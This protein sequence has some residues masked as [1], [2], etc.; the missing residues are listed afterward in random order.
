MGETF[1]PENEDQLRDAIAWAVSETAPLELAGTGTKSAI[2]RAMQTRA[3]LDLSA[4]TGISLYEPEELVLSAGAGTLRSEVEAELTSAGQEFAFEPPDFSILLGSAHAGTVGGMAAGNLA[5]PRRIKAGAARDHFLG[6]RA[7]SGRG[8][9]FKSGS[10]VMK[11]VTGYDLSKAMAGSWG[12]LAA[13][14]EV[15]FKVL[16]AAETQTTLLAGGLEPHDAVKV[17][18]AAMQSCCDVS[19]AAYLPADLAATLD[20]LP[21]G[22]ACLLRLEGFAPSVT[23]RTEALSGRLKDHVEVV[24]IDADVSARLWRAIRDVCFFR[25]DPERIV[26]RISVPPMNGANV[27]DAL[28]AIDGARAFMDWA[29]GLIWGDMPV[30]D[31]G[32]AQL[33]RGAI[34]GCGGHATLVRAPQTLRAAIP[35][36][37]PQPQAL[38]ALSAR[39]KDS[40]DPQGVL[41]PGRMYA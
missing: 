17:M 8:E 16:P 14:S 35:V 19:G 28:T 10:R 13:M 23:A 40:F 21:G 41:N 2:G 30:S 27:L 9:V 32:S 4:L 5:G 15:T 25:H 36:F 38:A 37:E 12:T 29:G 20:G 11:N 7:V 31:H 34:A 33:V 24:S 6:F 18:S 39:L 1:K 3:R 22:A 26:W